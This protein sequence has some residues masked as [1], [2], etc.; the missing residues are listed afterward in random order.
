M[1]NRK[2]H[3]LK[4]PFSRKKTL[5]LDDYESDFSDEFDYSDEES[6]SENEELDF[7]TEMKADLSHLDTKDQKQYLNELDIQELHEWH[8]SAVNSQNRELAIL[9]GQAAAAKS[10]SEISPWLEKMME[11]MDKKPGIEDLYF[12]HK[13]VEG[14]KGRQFK[15]IRSRLDSEF[16]SMDMTELGRLKIHAEGAGDSVFAARISKIAEIKMYTTEPAPVSREEAEAN[17][18]MRRGIKNLDVTD[19]AKL[20]NFAETRGDTT[21][22]SKVSRRAEKK[23]YTTEQSAPVRRDTDKGKEKEK[24]DES[25]QSKMLDKLTQTHMDINTSPNLPPKGSVRARREHFEK[26]IKQQELERDNN[27]LRRK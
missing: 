24:V 2:R 25:P 11:R 16:K 17:E 20:K 26:L 8:K 10:K 15:E 22:A 12:L 5:K 6:E 13:V 1:R 9:I 19:L 27:K 21:L 14:K 3:K 23:M 18:L 7:D 4:N